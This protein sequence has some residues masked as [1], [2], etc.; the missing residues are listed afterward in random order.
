MHYVTKSNN[1]T[2][3]LSVSSWNF[4]FF[5]FSAQQRSSQMSKKKAAGNQVKFALV[6]V[7]SSGL[8]ADTHMTFFYVVTIILNSLKY[9]WFWSKTS[10]KNEIYAF[11][12]P[13]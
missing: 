2:S 10:A 4:F 9:Y 3:I 12:S 8:G 1:W 7:P 11:F 13:F 6:R 5:L